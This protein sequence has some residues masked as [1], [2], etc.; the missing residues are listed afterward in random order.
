MWQLAN[1]HKAIISFFFKQKKPKKP[2]VSKAGS[3]RKGSR[4]RRN[5]VPADGPS[6]DS[7]DDEAVVEANLPVEDEQSETD[8]AKDVSDQENTRSV[9]SQAV[10]EAEEIGLFLTEEE[11]REALGLFPKVRF[12]LLTF[13]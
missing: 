9:R 13:D 3:S 6:D 12:W 10:R 11:I 2:K 1:L 8:P 4:R 5:S 7:V